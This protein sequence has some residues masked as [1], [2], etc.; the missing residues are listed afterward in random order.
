LK[1]FLKTFYETDA[2]IQ[3]GT[4]YIINGI[5]YGILVMNIDQIEA[6]F[7]YKTIQ[8]YMLIFVLP[9]YIYCPRTIYP[10]EVIDIH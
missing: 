10:D 1:N 6:N 5:F 7:I 9:A 8:K 2:L 3:L 4:I